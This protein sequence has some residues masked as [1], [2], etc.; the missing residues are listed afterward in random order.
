MNINY[1]DNLIKQDNKWNLYSKMLTEDGHDNLKATFYNI[2]R[3][4][5]NIDIK[6]KSIVEI[7]SGKG[8][9]SIY[10][11]LSNA[12]KVVSIEPELAGSRSKVIELQ[13]NRINSLGLDNIIVL[14]FDFNLWDSQGEKFDIVLSFASINHIYESPYNA[15]KHKETFQKYVAIGSKIHSLLK[16]GGI[17]VINDACRYG[18]FWFI[19]KLGIR[20]PWLPKKKITINWRIH[21]NPTTWKKILL[22]SGFSKIDIIYPLPYSLRSLKGV[23]DTPLF[24]FLLSAQFT[25]YCYA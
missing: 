6:D 11:S 3:T 22:E 9:M 4:F 18:L 7:G 21:Q 25:L 12:K 16:P 23:V 17:A 15:L 10:C 2:S 13:N 24:N 8:L 1:S 20:R 14:P 19:G 5:N